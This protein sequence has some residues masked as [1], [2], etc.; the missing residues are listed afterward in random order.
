MICPYCGRHHCTRGYRGRWVCPGCRN[1]FSCLVGTVF[2]NTKVSLRKW[3][4]AIYQITC[5]KKGISSCQLARDLEVTQTTAWYMLQK[6][7]ILLSQG[8]VVLEGDVEIDEV[9]VGGKEYFKHRTRK[10]GGTRGRS[11]KGK[12]PV[13][14][15][16]RRGDPSRV[17]ARQ[18]A[19]ADRQTVIPMVVNVCKHGSTLYT[20]ELS[21]YDVLSAK[22]YDHR[23]VVHSLKDYVRGPA[24][25]NSI[26][27]FW[28]HLKRMISGTYHTVSGTRLQRY[29]D[30][31]VFRWNH[32]TSTPWALFDLLMF[33]TYQITYK[34]VRSTGI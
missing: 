30:E 19:R 29:V 14:G 13:I 8:E 18:V 17:Y 21:I 5:H 6:I 7:R 11:T 4:V 20:D 33:K 10:V 12:I 28:G 34:T 9:Y 2:E 32:R 15:M 26:E 16:M 3:F 25:T 31:Q 27:G 24:H 22:G 1:K 23:V